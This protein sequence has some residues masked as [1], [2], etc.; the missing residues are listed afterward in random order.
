MDL[1]SEP[2]NLR[3]G[4]L[5][6]TDISH[7]NRLRQATAQSYSKLADDSSRRTGHSTDYLYGINVNHEHL[8]D[9]MTDRVEGGLLHQLDLNSE[10]NY[11]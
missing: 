9:F 2:I 5:M 1:D 3:Y 8:R 4:Q 6:G 10:K 11:I 7:Y